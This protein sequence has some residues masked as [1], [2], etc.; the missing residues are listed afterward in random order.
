M[1]EFF[2]TIVVGAI[3]I[4]ILWLYMRP[5][6]I[7]IKRKHEKFFLIFFTNLF[8]GWKLDMRFKMM[9]LAKNPE[10]GRD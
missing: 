9:D 3:I 4:G 8:F 10:Y 7:A 5:T 2:A 1:E 6:V